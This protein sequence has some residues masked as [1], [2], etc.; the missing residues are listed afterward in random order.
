MGTILHFL[1][2]MVQRLPFGGSSADSGGNDGMM[3]VPGGEAS[4]F[5]LIM[6]KILMVV[7]GAFT[8]VVVLAILY[9]L[10]RTI[11]K[12]LVRL[13][14][15]FSKY[16]STVSEDYEDEITDTRDYGE[17]TRARSSRRSRRAS[18]AESKDMPAGERIRRRYLRLLYKHPEW[19]RGSTARENLPLAAAPLYEQARYSN[20][21]LTDGDAERFSAGIKG[22]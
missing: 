17:Q 15:R 11:W 21:P 8:V 1:D 20:H 4:Q 14:H 6:Q 12:A 2:S 13:M 16:M 19:G 22:L 9:A 10:G 18:V 3:G 5:A 7:G